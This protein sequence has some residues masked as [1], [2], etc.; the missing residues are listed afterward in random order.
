MSG[1]TPPGAANER[2]ASI[3]VRQMF[4]EV[5][6]RYDLLNHLLSFNMDRYWRAQTVSA[7]AP[8]LKTAGA[9][10]LDLA[11]GTGDLTLALRKNARAT[12]IGSDFCHPMLA[13]AQGKAAGSVPLLEAD[14]LRLPVRD[15]SLDLITMAFGFRNLANYERGMTELRRALRPGATLAILEF[16]TPPHP[17]FRRLYDFYSYRVLPHIG[18]AVSGA[19][20]AYTYLPES[21]RKF[22]DA[23]GFAELMRTAGF[24]DVRYRRMTLGIVALHTGRA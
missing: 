24:K 3:Y 20:E 21:V 8:I 11:C 19:K 13:A 12:V 7:L 1:T 16:S 2:E 14:A 4:A 17:L 10:A 23:D 5:A 18:R 9:V 15:A 6:P 22:P